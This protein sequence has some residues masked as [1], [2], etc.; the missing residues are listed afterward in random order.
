MATR[1]FSPN[2]IAI[3]AIG[4]AALP[5]FNKTILQNILTKDW[6]KAHEAGFRNL[7]MA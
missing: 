1:N 7:I 5:E 6:I 4:K 3:G 2:A